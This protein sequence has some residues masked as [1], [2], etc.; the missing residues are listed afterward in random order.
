MGQFTPSWY[1]DGGSWDYPSIPDQTAPPTPQPAAYYFVKDGVAYS[2]LHLDSEGTPSHLDAQGKLQKYTHTDLNLPFGVIVVGANEQWFDTQEAWVDPEHQYPDQAEVKPDNGIWGDKI[3]DFIQAYLD[4]PPPGLTEEQLK[5]YRRTIL[6]SPPYANYAGIWE[7]FRLLATGNDQFEHKGEPNWLSRLNSLITYLSDADIEE[8]L[9]RIHDTP[10]PQARENIV[11]EFLA[12]AWSRQTSAEGKTNADAPQTSSAGDVYPDNFRAMMDYEE[13]LLNGDVD[14]VY[15][16]PANALILRPF[17][18]WP[19]IYLGG[20]SPE[21]LPFYWEPNRDYQTFEMRW[22]AWTPWGEVPENYPKDEIPPQYTAVVGDIEGKWDQKLIVQM[23]EVER[24]LGIK[25]F[26]KESEGFI[27]N[28]KRSPYYYDYHPEEDVHA[29]PDELIGGFVKGAAEDLVATAILSF[30]HPGVGLAYAGASLLSGFNS[31]NDITGW[32]DRPENTKY[33]EIATAEAIGGVVTDVV[34][35]G[36]DAWAVK[37]AGS[38]KFST[39]W[40]QTG[41]LT[42]GG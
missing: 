17:T 30:L 21:S 22:H 9:D 16:N 4:N 12:R 33:E 13:A 32:P 25:A 40:P 3:P 19:Q 6:N 15:Q 38:A 27:K 8:Y 36:I 2:C 1:D 34:T 26:T 23:L 41:Q 18:D 24:T 7:H 37:K 29:T 39:P 20:N 35:G 31:D 42:S 14:W 5:Q 28:D 11:L 10:S